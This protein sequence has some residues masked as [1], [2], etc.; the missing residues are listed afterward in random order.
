MNTSLNDNQCIQALRSGD[1]ATLRRIY[2]VYS[3]EVLRMVQQT[4]GTKADAADVFQS[5]LMTLYEKARNNDLY[6]PDGFGKMLL[7]LC[8][9]TWRNRQQGPK[10]VTDEEPLAD[11]WEEALQY[12]EKNQMF[13]QYFKQLGDACQLLLAFFFAGHTFDTICEQMHYGNSQ[14]AEQRKDQCKNKLVTLIKKDP[15]FAELKL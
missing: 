4:G 1:N 12:E 3:P 5:A 10:K 6:L 2:A 7:R 14:E 15:R 8:Q 13:R 11:D 9:Q